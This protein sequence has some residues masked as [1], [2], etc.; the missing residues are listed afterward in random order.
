MDKKIILSK[1]KIEELKAELKE[2]EGEDKKELSQT[3]ERA[4][5]SDVSEDADDVIV[6]MREL[7]K[8]D[9]RIGEIKDI[10]SN[11][12]VLKKNSCSK[13]KIEI[14]CEVDVQVGSKKSK[15]HMVSEI[16]SD[17]SK[18]KISDKSPLGK[19][20]MKSKEGDT[21]KIKVSDREIVYKVLKIS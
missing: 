14:G 5:L 2:L 11:S 4:R 18:G 9:E 6:V 20:L 8:L 15:F 17:P 3:L 12:S 1:E 7:E 19:A 13:A 10:L 16:E 21:I